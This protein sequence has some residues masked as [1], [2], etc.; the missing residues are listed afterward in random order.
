MCTTET[1]VH[2]P[3]GPVWR[4]VSEP[5]A[6]AT[7][8]GHIKVAKV[9]SCLLQHRRSSADAIALLQQDWANVR[10]ITLVYSLV[11]ELLPSKNINGC[12]VPK[13]LY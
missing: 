10:L 2:G 13:T 9:Y 5:E 8:G 3:E 4:F 1:L 6:T 11:A 12:R 7:Q